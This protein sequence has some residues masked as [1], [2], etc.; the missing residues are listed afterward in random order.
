VVGV[1]VAV[2]VRRVLLVRGRAV[3]TAVVLVH[4]GV[5]LAPADEP[6]VD[7]HSR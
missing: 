1:P 2:L 6:A 5:S 4:D 7:G 3:S